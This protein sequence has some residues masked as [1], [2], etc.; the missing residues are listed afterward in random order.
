MK[1]TYIGAKLL[2]A[3]PMDRGQYN[4]YRGWTIPSNENPNDPGYLVEYEDG[5][6][7]W[8][9]KSTFETAYRQINL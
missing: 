8:S 2:K 1:K 4:L 3:E 6:E 9:P 5:Y 7:S